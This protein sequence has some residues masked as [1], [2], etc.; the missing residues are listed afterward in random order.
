MY[1]KMTDK[2]LH[3]QTDESKN[4]TDQSFVINSLKRDFKRSP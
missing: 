1:T 2:H 4:W 3:F